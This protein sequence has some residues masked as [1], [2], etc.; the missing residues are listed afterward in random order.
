MS[1]DLTVSRIEGGLALEQLDDGKV[2]LVT[3]RTRN[4]EARLSG[5][6]AVETIYLTQQAGADASVGH[7]IAAVMAWE[8][9]AGLSIPRNAVL[10]RDLILSLSTIHAHLRNFYLQA[11]PDYIPWSDLAAYRGSRL[12][13][14]RI[15]RN[16]KGRP[17]AYWARQSQPHPFTASQVERIQENQMR[18]LDAL[19]AVQRMLA[20]LA[21]KFPMV[22]S[23]VPGGCSIPLTDALLIGLREELQR[24]APV[25]DGVGY[26]DATLVMGGFPRLKSLGKTGM[27]LLCVGTLGQGQSQAQPLISAGTW[28]GERFET[29]SASAEESVA[30][31]YYELPA[32]RRT[33]GPLL[34]PSP[35]KAGAYS[36]IKAP[37]LQGKPMEVGPL[38]RLALLHHSIS[39]GDTADLL[40]DL[41]KACGGTLTGASSVTGRTLARQAEARILV[42]R[43]G[44]LLDQLAPGQPTLADET[45]RRV[46]GD[47]VAEVESPAGALRHT[48][49]LSRSNVVLWDIVGPSTW[50]GSPQDESGQPGPLE[51][52]LT[53]AGLDLNR[54]EDRLTA[55]RIVHS[56]AFSTVDAIH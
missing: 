25:A 14:Q 9:A 49:S 33:G 47:G 24:I 3:G 46:T 53:G 52:A 51:A 15:A 38:A 16:L 1:V 44:E 40:D 45:G 36:W 43:C 31:S 13:L 18:A 5:R 8:N 4:V 42:R 17:A 20:R 41:A 11:L 37:R 21:G 12:E 50:N 32:E 35:S 55:S 54:K 10:L 39:A 28:T 19:D 27:G 22:M 34:Q 6:A 23:V 48:A 2:L 30:R 26:D 7:A 56:F 29:D